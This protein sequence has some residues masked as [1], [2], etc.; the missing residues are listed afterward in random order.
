MSRK[1]TRMECNKEA[2]RALNRNGVD[3]SYCQFTCYGNEVRLTGWLCKTDG[4][5]FTGPLIEAI[6]HDFKKCL[7]GFMIY[8]D[9]ENW[10]FNSDRIQYV[11][12]RKQ[13]A[14]G[15]VLEQE[16]YEIDLD[17]YDFEAS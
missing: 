15:E 14:D 3:L 5:D 11:G 13:N 4:S 12:E 2:R 1:L 10:N 9:F 16:V 7:P 6:I 8:G 17:D